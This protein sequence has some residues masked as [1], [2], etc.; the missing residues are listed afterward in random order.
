MTLAERRSLCWI[1]TLAVALSVTTGCGSDEEPATDAETAAD[2]AQQQDSGALDSAT[3]PDATATDTAPDGTAADTDTAADTEPDTAAA[4]D[5]ALPACTANTDCP[6]SNEPCAVILC[7]PDKRCAYVSLADQAACQDGDDCTIGETCLAQQCQ[8]GQQACGCTSQ[9]DCK[10]LDDGNACNGSLYCDD[11]GDQPQCKLNPAT[12]VSCTESDEPCVVNLCQPVTGTCALQPRKDGVSCDDGDPCT[13]SE[14]CLSGQCTAGADV[15]VCKTTADCASKEDGDL[16]NGTLYCDNTVFPRA[17]KVNPTTLVA[18]NKDKDSPCLHN[19]CA[20]KTGK[21]GWQAAPNKSACEDG[22]VCTKGDF[23]AAGLC[24]AGA[25]IC[26]CKTHTDCAAHEDGNPCTGT[27]YC[28][29][30][31]TIPSCRVNPATIVTCPTGADNT[32]RKSLCNKTNGTCALTPQNHLGACADGNPCS[33]GD[34]CTAGK[35]QSGPNACECKTDGDCSAHED[36]DLCNG[37]LYCDKQ[38]A[39]FRCAVLPKSVVRCKSANDTECLANRC[40]KNSGLCALTPVADTQACDADG[41][42]CTASDRCD[43]G[44]CVA[45][46]NVCKCEQSTDCGKY[47][48]GNVCNGSL[49]CDKGKAQPVCNVNPATTVHCPDGNDTECRRSTCQPNNGDCAF[50]AVFQGEPCNGD[51]NAC[52]ADDACDLGECVTGTNTCACTSDSDC[53]GKDDGNLCNGALFCDKAKLPFVCNVDPATVVLCPADGND[54]DC[55]APACVP[56]SGACTATFRAE[57]EACV[58]GDV[59]TFGDRCS[60]GKCV[61]G[62]NLCACQKDAECAVYD[63]GD[64]CNGVFECDKTNPPWACRPKANSAV[65]CPK[66]GSVCARTECRTSDGL[67]VVLPVAALQAKPC[68]DGDA[69]TS[70]TTCAG[71][72]CTAGVPTDCE[73]ANPCTHDS[74]TKLDQKG[75]VNLP[76]K[77]TCDDGN[78]CTGGDRC[79]DGACIA[80]SKLTCDDDNLCT[81]DSCKPGKSG[82]SGIGCQHEAIAGPCTDDNACT[83]TDTCKDGKCAPG[84]T[85]NCDDANLCTDDSCRPAPDATGAPESAGCQH[86]QLTKPC[87]DGDACTGGDACKNGN[88]AAGDKLSCDDANTCTADSCDP[89]NAT[90][91][92]KHTENTGPCE[93]GK[94]CSAGGDCEK[95]VCKPLGKDRLFDK[96]YGGALNDGF[97]AMVV[98]DDLGVMVAGMTE[99]DAKG[100]RDGWIT[101]IDKGGTTKWSTLTGDVGKDEL[102]GLVRTGDGAVAV[103]W[104]QSTATGRDFKAVRIG[105]DGKIV[106]TGERNEPG[107]DEARAVIRAAGQG[108]QNEGSDIGVLTVGVIVD[109]AAVVGFSSKGMLT[110]TELIGGPNSEANAAVG[111]QQGL[112]AV[113]GAAKLA[114]VGQ[115]CVL[116]LVHASGKLQKTVAFGGADDELCYGIARDGV[117]YV[118]VG[119]EPFDGKKSRIKVIRTDS[120]GGLT[121]QRSWSVK[122]PAA[123]RAVAAAATGFVLGGGATQGGNDGQIVRFGGLG[124]EQWSRTYGLGGHDEVFAVATL[125]DGGHWVAGLT[126]SYSNGSYDGWLMR[127]DPWGHISCY[128]SGG[129]ANTSPGTCADQSPCTRDICTS[130]KG[131]T[132]PLQPD[133]TVCGDGTTCGAGECK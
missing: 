8:G 33:V 59:C 127:M 3:A 96:Y 70:A 104:T 131:C 91:P 44:E 13:A 87:D 78:V 71:L 129:C 88:C 99:S 73:D 100:G 16:C 122:L 27:L 107:H 36:G 125:P 79:Q 93:D 85:K 11:S 9:A 63:D 101:R 89:K 15:C 94:L 83:D 29:F 39:P 124:L 116:S 57:N 42:P 75:C 132:H 21:C 68:D 92:C 40:Q 80:G 76:T 48:D 28:D 82:D 23:C 31:T 26:P 32:C 77:V 6:A 110:V 67:C 126:S 52:T 19:T 133:F 97:K 10:A 108:G 50:E 64:A 69:C 53:D 98:L 61:A 74:C 115:Q 117:G 14:Q 84:G 58:D 47:E 7:G 43:K 41:N 18:C 109:K 17:C 95:G 66:P 113:A 49:Y 12:V 106:W 60:A 55:I 65:V 112:F 121:W 62:K 90:T 24:T 37:T 1:T 38:K 25:D 46:T 35:C 130:S 119:Q 2:T 5:T 103:G 123:G 20:P 30:G 51:D 105:L 81:A 114:G 45:G 34:H 102:L 56:L 54:D 111:I 118:L 120:G 4:T 22:N 72:L 86:N 128:E